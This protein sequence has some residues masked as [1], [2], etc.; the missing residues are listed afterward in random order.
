MP[1]K[2]CLIC[3]QNNRKKGDFV[4]YLCTPAILDYLGK[5][6]TEK[7]IFLFKIN[8]GQLSNKELCPFEYSGIYLKEIIMTFVRNIIYAEV[9]SLQIVSIKGNF[10]RNC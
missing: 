8:V 2:K 4:F 5:P 3:S 7:V 9:T 1:Y 10:E 6:C